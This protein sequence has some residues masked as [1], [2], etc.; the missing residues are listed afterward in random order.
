MV[1]ALQL[2]CSAERGRQR[3]NAIAS[4]F[5]SV[6]AA[7]KG[8]TELSGC[9]ASTQVAVCCVLRLPC[10]CKS[11]AYAVAIAGYQLI[12]ATMKGIAELGSCRVCSPLQ[13]LLCC[14]AGAHVECCNSE[15]ESAS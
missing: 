1:D 5:R 12:Q 2:C 11:M 10:A 9:R 8:A 7:I 4:E 13:C 14:I 15:L 6:Q 3:R